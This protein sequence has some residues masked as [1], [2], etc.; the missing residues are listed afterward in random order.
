MLQLKPIVLWEHKEKLFITFV[1][2][3]KAYDS[4]PKEAMWKVLRKLG[5]PDV[6]VSLIKSFHQDMKARNRLD[7]KVD[8][9]NQWA[10]TGLLYGTSTFQP[11]HMCCYV[12]MV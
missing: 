6:M 11:L 12:E 8:G 9:L 4:V 1:D 7:K 2:L 5:V 3:K 10:E